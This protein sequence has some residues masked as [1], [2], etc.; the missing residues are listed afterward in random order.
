MDEKEE[1][2]YFLKGNG[3]YLDE[4]WLA[5]ELTRPKTLADI[6]FEKELDD[7]LA[8]Q[9]EKYRKAKKNKEEKETKWFSAY[10][11]G[12]LKWIRKN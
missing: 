3:Y 7:Y 2:E 10:L 5:E 6:E 4:N 12:G 1:K 11:K 8:K 9:Q